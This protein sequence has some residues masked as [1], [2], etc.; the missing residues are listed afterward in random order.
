MS[1]VWHCGD[2]IS[3]LRMSRAFVDQKIDEGSHLQTVFQQN[4]VL[5]TASATGK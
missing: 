2:A 3:P 1:G 4:H 5:P